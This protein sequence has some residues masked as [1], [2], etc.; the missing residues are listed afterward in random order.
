M[1]QRGCF[2]FSLGHGKG[3][4]KVSWRR[5]YQTVRRRSIPGRSNYKWR[6]CHTIQHDKFNFKKFILTKMQGM[7]HDQARTEVGGVSNGGQCVPHEGVWTV[8]Y[9]PGV[10]KLGCAHHRGRT[11]WS[12]GVSYQNFYCIFTSRFRKKLNF[13]NISFQLVINRSEW[14]TVTC[15]IPWA[16]HP[17]GKWNPT[18][19][20]VGPSPRHSF[21]NYC[22]MLHFMVSS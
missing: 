15:H 13:T 8:S 3:P 11:R 21:F 6:L 17:A 1:F 20:R 18:I 7:R 5:C 12:T 2:Q 14:Q 10:S 16:E 22:N 19:W 4:A 9:S